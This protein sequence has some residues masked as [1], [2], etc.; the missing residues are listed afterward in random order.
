MSQTLFVAFIQNAGLLLSLVFVFD[1]FTRRGMTT[2]ARKVLAGIAVG[3]IGIAIIGS[4]VPLHS[5]TIFDTR[6]VLLALSG[7]F[8]GGI[9]T[10]VGMLMTAAY[11]IALGGADFTGVAVI[12]ASGILG[13]TWRR[14]RRGSLK[15]VTW[16]ELYALGL[17]V[18]VVMLGLMF[19]MPN[20]VAWRVVKALVWPV[21]SVHPLATLAIGVLFTYSLRHQRTASEL[22]RS[23]S[24]FRLL[25][26]NARDMIFRIDFVPQR[27]WS[28]VSPASTRMSG[29]TPEDF[30]SGVVT[31]EVI[32]PDDR[33]M[34]AALERGESPEEAPVTFR[35]RRPDGE[36]IWVE[37]RSTLIRDETGAI[38]AMEGIVR[39]V[40]QSRQ[41]EE[42]RLALTEQLH[43]AQRLE[44]LGSLAGGVAHDINNVLT[45]ILSL[46]TGHRKQVADADPL[47][48]SLDTIMSACVR[49]R[50]VVRSLLYF[51][52]QDLEARGA[53]D[54]NVIVREIVDL[55]VNTTLR[56]VEFTTDLEESLPTIVGDAG[57]ISHAVMN[58][59]INALDAMPEG[60]TVVLSTR[61]LSGS[62]VELRVRDSGVGMTASVRER[63]IE[64][65]FT[66]KP[67]GKGTGLGLAT[68]FGTVQAHGGTFH[69]D[70]EP[71]N[72][73]EVVMTLPADEHD[74][75]PA[76]PVAV[77]GK[78]AGAGDGLEVLI[79]DDDQLIADAIG[80]LLEMEGHT[81]RVALGGA[82]GLA[83]FE[84]GLTV[85]LVVLDLNMP[86]MNGAETLARLLAIR[87]RQNVLLCS[88]HWEESTLSLIDRPNVL[89]LQK[90]FTLEEFEAKLDALGLR[91]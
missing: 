3:F 6:S 7:L 36:W 46:A 37:Q 45:A 19:T 53:V 13:L 71:G 52:S 91:G 48:R 82:E 67:L 75:D 23:E 80:T 29:F 5:G 76:Q 39:D 9:P 60:G 32:H 18:H 88:G 79:I 4:A 41:A 89:S 26:E 49:G 16:Q 69:I 83:Q 65:F 20:A 15:D 61:S 12:L 56:R 51:A 35:F 57:A 72:G 78:A 44:S 25:A 22:R 43:R 86:G 33:A 58:L 64:P 42:E 27:V 38:V 30:Y 77:S 10:T 68:V 54:L 90:P 40:T 31:H 8:L 14:L 66:T 24:R 87:P 50:S 28:Y 81:V 74:L 70:S 62:R 17:V 84:A 2:P 55:L 47:A 59:C 63:A 11:R 34:L 1:F 73:T 21:M 85:D